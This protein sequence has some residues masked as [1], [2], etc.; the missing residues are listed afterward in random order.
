VSPLGFI[1]LLHVAAGTVVLAVAPAAMI[2][3]KGG[4]WHRRW[5][6]AFALAMV[7][8]LA[9]AAFMWE[10][11]GHLFLLF[12]DA[13]SAYLV[14]AGYRTIARRRR[15]TRDA[16]AD[17]IDALAA[18]G[19]AACAAALA[20]I[21]AYARGPLMRELAGVLLALAAIAAAFAYLD[22][23]ALAE[24][25]Q[26]RLGSLLVHLSAMIAAYI[27]AVTAFVVINAHGVPMTLRWLVPSVAG[28]A[29]IAGFSI[30][31]RRRFARARR[32]SPSPSPSG[33]TSLMPT[34]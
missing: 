7:F 29:V 2:V 33:D 12:L 22:L 15:R 11:H 19:V 3:R 6:I 31:Y 24:R 14:F 9:S 34:R 28:S 25:K 1:T 27:S 8:V 17:R 4:A 26:S 21:G 10:S 32:A 23:K 5:G 30:A 16:R 13:V 18:G 20:G